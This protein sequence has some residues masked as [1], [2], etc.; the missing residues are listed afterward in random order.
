MAQPSQPPAVTIISGKSLC[1]F[2]SWSHGNCPVHKTY[3]SCSKSFESW[4]S[5]FMKILCRWF[6]VMM[7]KSSHGVGKS[8]DIIHSQKQVSHLLAP[9]GAFNFF[10]PLIHLLWNRSGKRK[11]RGGQKS[12]FFWVLLP[13]V[14]L[15]VLHPRTKLHPPP[16]PSHTFPVPSFLPP[17]ALSSSRHGERERG[18]KES[19]FVPSFSLFWGNRVSVLAAPATREEGRR[20]ERRRSLFATAIAARRRRLQRDIACEKGRKCNSW[21]RNKEREKITGVVI[22]S[23]S[24]FFSFS[25]CARGDTHQQSESLKKRVCFRG[26]KMLLCRA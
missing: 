1:I 5:S 13:S 15:A 14:C 6:A 8:Q 19:S 22:R 21:W 25:Q 17:P 16:L 24:A 7:G 2:C 4:I 20:R 23:R 10:C 3:V 12:P 9:G 18:R 11:E 26:T